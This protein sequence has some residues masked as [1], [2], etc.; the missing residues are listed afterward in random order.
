MDECDNKAPII[1]AMMELL[2]LDR[3][4]VLSKSKDKSADTVAWAT[5]C[6]ME[7]KTVLSTMGGPEYAKSIIALHTV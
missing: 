3:C 4:D 6:M 7:A 1:N 2:K 5:A